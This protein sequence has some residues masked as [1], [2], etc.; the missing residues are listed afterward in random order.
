[1]IIFHRDIK[2]ADVRVHG[3]GFVQAELFDGSKLH[4]WG[5]DCPRQDVPTLIHNHTSPFHSTI[6]YGILRN[7]EYVLDKAKRASNNDQIYDMYQAVSRKKKDTGLENM[8][9][10]RYIVSRRK[11]YLAAGST[12]QFPG[13]ED[14]FHATFPETDL[15][16][17][18]VFRQPEEQRNPIVLVPIE[19][20][21][22]NSFD[23]YEHEEY[24]IAIYE[25]V[26]QMVRCKLN[27]L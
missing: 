9:K 11:F 17:T 1:M 20:K 15:V 13:T 5:K 18:R 3:N 16:V 4:I 24:A 10:Q 8:N 14:L 22:D 26:R 6:L 21:P 7:E 12:Y 23:R 19:E 2:K 25:K 27:V